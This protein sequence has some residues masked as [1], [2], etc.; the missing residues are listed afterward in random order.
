M[1][2]MSIDYGLLTYKKVFNISR[3]FAFDIFQIKVIPN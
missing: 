1:N 2:D 3:L